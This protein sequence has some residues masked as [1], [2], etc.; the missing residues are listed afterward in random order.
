[1]EEVIDNKINDQAEM[2]AFINDPE[3]RKNATS[4]ALQV[5]Q[6][7][8]KNWFTLNRFIKKTKETKE[9]SLLKLNLLK[10]F[11]ML[12]SKTADWKDGSEARGR[13]VYKV[14]VSNEDKIAGIDEIIDYYKYQIESLERQKSQLKGEK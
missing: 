8:G 11:G 6:S 13:Q 3:E 5:Q 10:I 2:L 12:Q 1:M 7:V 14:A 9:S 4:L